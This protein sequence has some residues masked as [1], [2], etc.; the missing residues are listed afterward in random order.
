MN[1]RKFIDFFKTKSGITLLLIAGIFVGLAF[2]SNVNSTK[3]AE[4]KAKRE[5][6]PRTAPLSDKLPDPTKEQSY[7]V[8]LPFHPSIDS[9]A[10]SRRLIAQK[11]RERRDAEKKESS[12]KEKPA[13]RTIQFLPTSAQPIQAPSQPKPAN[14]DVASRQFVNPKEPFAPYGRMIRA[15]LV[16]AVDSG[17]I[18]TPVMGLV[19]HDLYWND[20]IIIP[21]NSELHSVATPDRERNRI[22]VTGNWIVVLAKGG[23]YP[24]GSE[25]VLQGT[26]L[27]M[28]VEPESAQ[29]GLSDGSAGLRGK[30]LSNEDTWNT[31]KLFAASFLAGATEGLTERQTNAF[32]QS[33]VVPSM[34]SGALQGTREVMETYAERIMELIDR[35]GAYVHVASG[36][37]FYLYV[38]QPILLQDSKLAGT[39]AKPQLTN[40][41][42]QKLGGSTENG[43]LEKLILSAKQDLA[44]RRAS[45][46]AQNTANRLLQQ[47]M[48]TPR[49]SDASRRIPSS[50]PQ[51]P[52][53]NLSPTPT[54]PRQ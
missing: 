36:K 31:V 21:A 45:N 16:T 28:D 11:E 29:F 34:E 25:L 32:G 33:Q 22:E 17:N 52:A 39:L 27:D 5:G 23:Q 51:L 37:Q 38:T 6:A 49:P 43:E 50:N 54:A 40:A 12:K 10:Q 3:E 4:R 41:Q 1:P 2:I 48:L 42:R 18:R 15:E 46:D 47:Q 7:I 9:T 19:T 35:D 20:K 13:K 30:I 44:E 14:D 53:I 24:E 26:A 8:N